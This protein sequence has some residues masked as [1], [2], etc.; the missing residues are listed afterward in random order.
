[1]TRECAED[2]VFVDEIHGKEVLGELLVAACNSAFWELG[3]EFFLC[4]LEEVECR[5]GGYGY[6][7]QTEKAFVAIAP[8]LLQIFSDFIEVL[9]EA[10]HDDLYV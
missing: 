4:S 2:V 6:S 9:E 1:M 5:V 7:C 10:I 8:P 3:V